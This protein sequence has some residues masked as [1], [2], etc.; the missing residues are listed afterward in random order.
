MNHI[1]SKILFATL[2]V[3]LVAETELAQA[4]EFDLNGLFVGTWTDKGRNRTD[5]NFKLQLKQDGDR[6]SGNTVDKTIWVKGRVVELRIELEWDHSSGEYGKG[7][8]DI[9]DDGNRLR[10]SWESAGSGRFDGDW[11][12]QRQ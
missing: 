3:A 12:L 8:F 4:S 9:L 11:D 10:G 7:Y 5:R 1:F 2:L 6:I